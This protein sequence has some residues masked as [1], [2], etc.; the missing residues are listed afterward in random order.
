MTTPMTGLDHMTVLT[1]DI[2][3]AVDD[4]T[5][6]LAAKAWPGGAGD[7]AGAAIFTLANTSIEL[8]APVGDGTA[9]ARVRAVLDTRGEGL[10][11]V[12]FRVNDVD[13]MARRLSQLQLQPEPVAEAGSV[14]LIDGA[15]LRWRRTPRG[16]RRD[17]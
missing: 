12:C 15:T 8:M 17:P 9:G 4:Y 2:A 10:A 3:R 16:T 14:N 5:A 7:G 11:S 1:R 6:P 13:R